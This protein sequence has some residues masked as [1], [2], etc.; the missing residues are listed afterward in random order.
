MTEFSQLRTVKDVQLP[1]K[2][3]AKRIY[4]SIF[5]KCR[6]E[7]LR[8]KGVKVHILDKEFG[9]DAL[10]HMGSGQW[11]SIQEKY[12]DYPK[13]T[14]HDFTQEIKNGDGTDGEWQKLGAQLYFYGWGDP[15]KSVFLEWFILDISRYKLIIER[16]GGI[17]KAGKIQCNKYDGASIF[18]GIPFITVRP[19]MLYFGTGSVYVK[20][21]DDRSFSQ[22]F[23]LKR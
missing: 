17:T 13:W 18:V 10:L 8:E 11:F 4:E 19:A 5:P 1:L 12:R 21:L 2:T 7:D 20:R 16:L 15:K 23:L 9:I 22:P 14:F 6:I 3:A